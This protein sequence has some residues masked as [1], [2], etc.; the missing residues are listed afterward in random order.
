MSNKFRDHL[1]IVPEDQKNNDLI[2]GFVNATSIASH[3]FQI[4][5]IA[6]GWINAVDSLQ[7]MKLVS[8]PLRRVLLVIDF[9]EKPESRNDQVHEKLSK[10]LTQNEYERVYLLGTRSEPED[11]RSTLKM[12]PEQVGAQL[13]LDCKTPQPGL[14][15]HAL[16]AHNL[17]TRARLIAEVLPF[18]INS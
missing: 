15:G 10:F 12:S 8:L 9:D 5:R 13:Y 1:V 18:L 2:N 7:D 16:F 3:A 6:R 14:W 4:Q 17:K 11:F